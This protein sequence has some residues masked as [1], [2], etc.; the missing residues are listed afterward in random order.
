[1][2]ELA[3]EL[4]AVLADR[5]VLDG[6]IPVV[7]FGVLATRSIPLAAGVA[8]A[9]AVAISIRRR[10][11]GGT[12]GWAIGGIAG[13][14]LGAGLAWWSGSAGGFFL[15]GVVRGG[16]VALVG[17]VSLV[18]P[19]PMVAWTSKIFRR[20]PTDWYRHPSVRPAYVETTLL[21][22]V[23][24]AGRAWAQWAALEAS[25]GLQTALAVAT[26]WPAT[27]ALLVVTYVY[28][29]WRLGRLSGPSVE[30]WEA[31]APPPWDGQQRGF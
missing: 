28:G 30:E 31:G 19:L 16:A 4:A 7:V 9:V 23:F 22:V 29:R 26:G 5:P 14:A 11:V 1:M 17:L 25:A 8:L 10:F 20:W 6:A 18:L 2:K 24:F 15:P 21:W 12:Q 27:I 13:V 3:E